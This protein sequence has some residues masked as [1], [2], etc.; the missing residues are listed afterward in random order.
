ME[1][2]NVNTWTAQGEA[3]MDGEELRAERDGRGEETGTQ[4]EVWQ[5]AVSLIGK[6]ISK[7]TCHGGSGQASHKADK[8][9]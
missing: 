3:L 7:V 2:N 1:A 9:Q 8:E 4:G 6:V 5:P